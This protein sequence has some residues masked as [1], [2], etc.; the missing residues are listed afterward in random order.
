[1]SIAPRDV[2]TR[3]PIAVAMLAIGCS[4]SSAS[5]DPRPPPEPPKLAAPSGRVVELPGDGNGA[6]W[7]AP[8]STLYVT[9][10][11]HGQLV[12]WTDAKGISVVGS[13]GVTGRLGL[14]AL[15]R[16]D[17][18]TFVTPSFGFGTDGNVLTYRDT[19]G[20]VPNLDRARRRIGLARTPAGALYVAYFIVEPGSKHRGGVAKL[21]LSGSETDL[22]IPGLG[23]P[24]GLAAN[25][26]TLYIA[27]Q[28]SSS[29]LAYAFDGGQVT[30]VASGLPS[31][32]LLTLL[33]NGDLVTGGKKGAVYRIAKSGVVS[34]IASGFEQARGTAYDPAG[35]RLFVVEHSAS[36][37]KH[38]LHV[39]PYD[40]R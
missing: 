40:V 39:I 21:E 28:E 7:D 23:K 33:P 26:S 38:R 9:D 35:K 30:T 24:V 17:D 31:A 14:G 22:A 10:D 4:G 16:L 3:G 36:T 25:A 32:D 5:T 19:A 13:F 27:D 1:M 37:S 15:V 6:Y 8:S 29:V 12:A 11:T 34:T 20:S 18:G 2:M